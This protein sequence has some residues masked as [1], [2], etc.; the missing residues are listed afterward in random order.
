MNRFFEMVLKI[1]H[2]YYIR[3][4]ETIVKPVHYDVIEIPSKAEEIIK[5]GVINEN[6]KD[7]SATSNGEVIYIYI[8]IFYV[9]PD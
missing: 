2:F 9:E 6:P 8:V 1:S 5:N 4:C 3:K 7:D